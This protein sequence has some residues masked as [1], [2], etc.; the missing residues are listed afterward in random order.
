MERY[1]GGKRNFIDSSGELILKLLLL[2]LVV[3]TF[4]NL[5]I[6]KPTIFDIIDYK[7]H[8]KEIERKI[9]EELEKNEKLKTLYKNV[10][11]NPDYYMEIFVRE[12]LWKFK[13]G[14]KVV[15]LP[16]ELR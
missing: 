14:E 4:V 16:K 1:S 10:K 13:R 9:K 5:F 11:R 15:P 8:E 6:S 3:N 2:L 12:Y 7:I